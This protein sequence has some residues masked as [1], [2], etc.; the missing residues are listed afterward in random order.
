MKLSDLGRYALGITLAGCAGSQTP[1]GAPG[2]MP[3]SA[4]Q[5]SAAVG[6]ALPPAAVGPNLYV[7]N[8]HTVKVYALGSTSVLRTI[9]QVNKFPIALAFDSRG[10]LYVADPF[11]VRVYAR[12]SG[13]V[14]R[15]LHQTGV[16]KAL[17]FDRSG[18]L[19]VA[20][21]GPPFV[22]TRCWGAA[23]PYTA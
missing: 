11:E 9:S 13:T 20:D 10:H 16:P 21:C 2:A 19:Y 12:D 8:D 7:A 23:L 3:H 17:A 4:T 22:F 18:N 1:F 5:Q 14:L 6:S 15:N